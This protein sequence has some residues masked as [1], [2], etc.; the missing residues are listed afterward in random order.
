MYLGVRRVTLTDVDVLAGGCVKVM[1]EN[2]ASRTSGTSPP[3]SLSKHPTHKPPRYHDV[4]LHPELGNLSAEA[5]RL[6]AQ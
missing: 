1:T 2:E 6:A 3:R 5:K 4:S